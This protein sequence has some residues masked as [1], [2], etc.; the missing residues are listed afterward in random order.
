M[1]EIKEEIEKLILRHRHLGLSL[2]LEKKKKDL[3]NLEKKIQTPNFWQKE[4]KAR[5]ISQKFSGLK[6]QIDKFSNFKKEIEDLKEISQLT[7]EGEK[8]EEKEIKEK[9]EKL[10]SQMQEFEQEFFFRGKY[11]KGG[12]ILS[13]QAGA[14]GRDAEDWTSLL[15]RMYQRYCQ[16]KNW[17]FRVLSQSFS[18]GG[19][20]EG[21]LGLKDVSLEIKGRSVYGLLKKE[22]GVHRLVRISPFSAKGLRH[23]SFAKVEVLPE[24]K[25]ED[26]EIKIKPQDLKIETFRASGPGGQN[27]NRRETAVRLTHLPTGLRAACQVERLQGANRK[28]A[29]QILIAKLAQQKEKEK[30]KELEKIKG[31]RVSPDFGSQ[32]RSYVLHPYKLV[33]D[34][35]TGVET[36]D[37]DCVLDGDLDRFVEE[38]IK[39]GNMKPET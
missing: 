5:E 31:K 9:I 21:R 35:R 2:E 32:I 15:L 22:S 20:P 39:S 7:K 29:L 16:R 12:I 4:K 6:K 28:L 13:I 11:D 8:E 37:V 25:V 18:E 26:S 33:K 3:N 34:H 10:N 24:I 30:E 17:I 38:E 14:G 36:S 27:V 1:K 19:G 23:T